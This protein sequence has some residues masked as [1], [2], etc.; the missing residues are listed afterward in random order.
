MKKSTTSE[1]MAASLLQRIFDGEWRVNDR[2][3]TVDELNDVMP[4]SRATI[5]KSLQSLVEKGYLRSVRG[6]GVYVQ[7]NTLLRHILV[8]VGGDRLDAGHP[9][10]MII[11]RNL[12]RVLSAANMQP[13]I[14][15]ESG[16]EALDERLVREMSQHRFHGVL[17]IQSNLPFQWQKRS[18][19][20]KVRLPMVHVG[21]H[22]ACPSVFIDM[23][24]FH[25]LALESIPPRRKILYLAKAGP[26]QTGDDF[27]Q[28]AI[29]C[30]YE[31]YL[32]ADSELAK[33]APPEYGGYHAFMRAW[34]RLGGGFDA[35]VV[36]DDVMGKGVAQ[37]LLAIGA[38]KA[39]NMRVVLL[40]NQGVD[41]FYPVPVTRIEVDTTRVADTAMRLLEM[42]LRGNAPDSTRPVRELVKPRIRT[43]PI[44]A[45]VDEC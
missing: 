7:N 44:P 45:G 16:S 2:L 3:P 20:K 42:G 43:T 17:S 29:S 4:A 15:L 23:A 9:F 18:E 6:S 1:M 5:H 19:S 35:V 22:T 30:G 27:Q 14:R 36:P 25:R 10:G 11:T 38:R 41:L 12:E 39:R 32:L 28:F 33:D 34:E 31:A 8:H 37:A 24:E 26:E 21:V 40:A 13:E